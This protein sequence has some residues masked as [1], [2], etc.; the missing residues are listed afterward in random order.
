[1]QF[2]PQRLLIYKPNS[3]TKGALREQV[4]RAEAATTAQS[5]DLLTRASLEMARQAYRATNNLAQG[6]CRS[7]SPGR[8]SHPAAT[9][10]DFEKRRS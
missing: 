7:D 1:L 10:S 3:R 4:N 8:S 5:G 6:L 9:S 2:K